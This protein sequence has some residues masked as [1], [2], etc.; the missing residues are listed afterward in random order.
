MLYNKIFIHKLVED[1]DDVRDY[2]ENGMAI[3][4][5]QRI[6]SIKRDILKASDAI[7]QQ[8]KIKGK[9]IAIRGKPWGKRNHR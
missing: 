8:T 3:A 2:V 7:Q 5:I 6:N 9:V 4:A 1:L